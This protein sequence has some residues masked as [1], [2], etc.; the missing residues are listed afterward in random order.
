MSLTL[1]AMEA[2]KERKKKKKNR[3]EA[4]DWGGTILFRKNGE[5]LV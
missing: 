3:E 5:N 1:I 2:R 4:A